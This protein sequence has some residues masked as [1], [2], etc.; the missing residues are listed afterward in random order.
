MK[1]KVLVG[2]ILMMGGL[3]LLSGMGLITLLE[4][5]PPMTAFLI[6]MGLVFI[7]L[8]GNQLFWSNL[9]D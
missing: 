1:W 6:W 7:T 4:Y 9:E 8:L 5:R 2:F 3:L